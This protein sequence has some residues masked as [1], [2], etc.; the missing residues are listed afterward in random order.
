[1]V[2]FDSNHGRRVSCGKNDRE[3][4]ISKFRLRILTTWSACH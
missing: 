2:K 1:M 4:S 3:K